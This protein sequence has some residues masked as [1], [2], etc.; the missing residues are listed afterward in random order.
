MYL[1]DAATGKEVGAVDSPNHMLWLDEDISEAAV[2]ELVVTG[3][4]AMI[5]LA[6]LNGWN[7]DM[8]VVTDGP[9][10]RMHW[11]HPVL[12]RLVPD[13]NEEEKR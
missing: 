7:A 2:K 8:A 9:G 3:L 5:M 11:V 13:L 4:A 6:P 1:R 12:D 10:G